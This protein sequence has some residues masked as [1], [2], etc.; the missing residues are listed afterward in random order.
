MLLSS[1]IKCRIKV[2]LAASLLLLAGCGGGSSNSGGAVEPPVGSSEPL[3]SIVTLGDSIGVGIGFGST[4]PWPNATARIVGVPILENRSL[5]SQTTA[6]G[7]QQ[8][9]SLLDANP[10]ASHL[11]ILMGTNDAR[12][13]MTS[14]AVANLQQM[15][16]IANQRGVVPVIGTVIINLADPGADARARQITA[17]IRGI[18]GARIAETRLAIGDGS[19]LLFDGLHPNNAGQNAI[20]Q[21][22]ADALAR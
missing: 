21:A 8:I 20:A 1:D 2:V 12:Q 6:W 19:G 7:L 13:G 22:F 5:K 14:S 3:T 10:G 17:D 16:N 15:A 11:L 18:V 4:F 9:R